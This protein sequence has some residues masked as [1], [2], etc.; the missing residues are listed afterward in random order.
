MTILDQLTELYWG[1]GE[2]SIDDRRRMKAVVHELS[3]IIRSW[4]PDESR[5][6]ISFLTIHEVAD[7]LLR[8]T[9]DARRQTTD[10]QEIAARS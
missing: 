1:L 3:Q 5:A 7:R 2:Y 9:E 8:E 6:R 10:A 4:A